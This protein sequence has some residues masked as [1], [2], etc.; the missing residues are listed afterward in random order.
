ML[1]RTVAFLMVM[2]V[3]LQRGLAE[4]APGGTA[5]LVEMDGAIGPASDDHLG[6]ALNVAA[7]RGAV[8]VVIRIN[9]PG[10][11]DTSMRAMIARILASPIPIVVY[12]APEGARAA[13]AGTFILYAAHIAAMAP[14]TSVG[15]AT[16][17]QMGGGGLSPGSDDEGKEKSP[18]P[19]AM[20]RKVTNDAVAYIRGMAELRG[21]NADWAEEAVRQ[22][23]SLTSSE[24]LEK[25]VID[26]LAPDVATLL[27][28]M[29]GRSVEVLR[30]PRVLLTSGLSVEEIHPD[31][32]TQLLGILTNPN[33]AFILMLV[34]IY[35]LIFEL[36]N[37]GAMIPGIA[38]AISLLLALFAFHLLPINYAG[39]ALIGFGIMLMAAEAFAPSFGALGIGGMVAFVLGAIIL[40]DGDIPGF[41]LYL[42]VILSFAVLSAIVLVLFVALA[43]KSFRL[44]RVSGQ[45]GLIGS[46]GTAMG[47]FDSEGRILVQGESWKAH[48]ARP[49]TAGQSVRITAVD[50]LVVH[51]EP[52]KTNKPTS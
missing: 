20:E 49:V 1:L 48:S 8:L 47:S 24:A 3:I 15:A 4:E 37:P 16:P 31:W 22:G 18:G 46:F 43:L 9:T 6:R 41:Q 5:I 42:S 14:A 12:V 45:E 7:E 33:V 19:G 26:F 17:V 44:P 40:I 21:R 39:L 36:A 50:G 32:R 30:Q 27:R 23:V 25:N 34:G 13:S 28:Q 52:S 10:G 35:G 51:V 29:D 2:W 38:G 11:L